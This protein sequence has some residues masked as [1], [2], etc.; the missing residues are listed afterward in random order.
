[1]VKILKWVGNIGLVLLVAVSVIM[2]VSAYQASKNPGELPSVFGYHIMNVL[3]GS[4]EPAF[5]PGDLIVVKS[6]SPEKRE[7]NDVIT[8]RD[9]QNTFITHRI[10]A[11]TEEQGKT[12]YQTKGDA[13]NIEDEGLISN[14]Q[15][16][17]SLQFHIP[18]AGKFVDMV[19]S[20][21]GLI[22]LA[23]IPLII[24]AMGIFTK[25]LNDNNKEKQHKEQDNIKEAK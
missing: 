23:M 13:N 1:M 14:E 21:T 12:L 15:I 8:Y 16:V 22:I 7:V 11:T 19:T 9:N 5:S 25:L 3:S 4:M 20:P 18:K 17:G 2:G 6:D 10:I 24:L